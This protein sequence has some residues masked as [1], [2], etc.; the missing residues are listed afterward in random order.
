MNFCTKI[1]LNFT[2]KKM[3]SLWEF[4]FSLFRLSVASS[5]SEWTIQYNTI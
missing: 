1:T 2:V 5:E 3:L 4:F